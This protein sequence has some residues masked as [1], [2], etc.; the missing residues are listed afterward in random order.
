MFLFAFIS[1]REKNCMLLFCKF[2]AKY[3]YGKII[4]SLQNLWSIC[5]HLS[6]L[7]YN[8]IIKKKDK[9]NFVLI[10]A[11]ILSEKYLFLEFDADK[12]VY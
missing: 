1:N 3:K 8:F 7:K 2:D 6:S 10:F 12:N 11:E 9:M 4:I 5:I